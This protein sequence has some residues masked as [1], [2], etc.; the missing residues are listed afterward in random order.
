M[1]LDSAPFRLTHTDPSLLSRSFSRSPSSFLLPLLSS[2]FSLLSTE[3]AHR[4]SV[5]RTPYTLQ[6]PRQTGR[7]LA[8]LLAGPVARGFA[9][10]ACVAVL[11]L[12]AV[13]GPPWP[14]LAL[15]ALL[16]LGTRSH[17]ALAGG[18]LIAAVS[19]GTMHSR[20]MR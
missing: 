16:L 2:L 14:H 5:C 7:A 6:P 3:R 1:L 17:A 10:A 4:C 8:R 9:A 19:L 18:A 11:A 13:G 15:A 20:G 12:G